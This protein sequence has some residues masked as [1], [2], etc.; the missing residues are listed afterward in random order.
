MIGAD[1]RMRDAT[2]GATNHSDPDGRSYGDWHTEGD[3]PQVDTMWLRIG[4]HRPLPAAAWGSTFA[5][6]TARGIMF[7]LAYCQMKLT[8]DRAG[9]RG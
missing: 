4:E 6:L 3:T 5:R 8:R 2:L 9:W 1:E 7:H